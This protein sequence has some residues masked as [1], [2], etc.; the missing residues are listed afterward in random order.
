MIMSP[1]EIRM[2][3]KHAKDRKKCVSILAELNECDKSKIMDIISAGDGSGGAGGYG[4]EELLKELDDIDRQIKILE[5]KY[6]ETVALLL[7]DRTAR[8]RRKG[9]DG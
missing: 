2:Q 1:G 5:E 9:A 7:K 3:Y 6:R 4:N 8:G